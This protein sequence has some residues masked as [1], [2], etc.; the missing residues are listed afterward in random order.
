MSDVRDESGTAWNEAA[1]AVTDT[2]WREA[3]Q[4][5]GAMCEKQWE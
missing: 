4:A 2:E 1:Q 5:I 3:I